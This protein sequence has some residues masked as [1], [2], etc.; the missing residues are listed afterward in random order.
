MSEHKVHINWKRGEIPFEYASY[1]RNHTW[2]FENGEIIG[3]SAAPAFKGDHSKIDPEA[4][5][6]AALSSC[7]MLTFLAIAAH[8]KITVDSYE[9]EAIGYLERD[10][11]GKN[12]IT[13]VILRPRISFEGDAPD[14]KT[15]REMHEKSH[16]ECFIARSVKTDVSVE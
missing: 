7:H 2:R 1:D 15:L 6:V 16:H 14:E 11:G 8:K 3:A 5:F 13:R 12:A 9:D 10:E 4:A